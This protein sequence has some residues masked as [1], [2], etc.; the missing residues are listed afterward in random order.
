MRCV[1]SELYLHI[2][3]LIELAS[4]DLVLLKNVP[5]LSCVSSI[6]CFSLCSCRKNG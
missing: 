1:P 2:S 3:V 6:I 5:F 4:F